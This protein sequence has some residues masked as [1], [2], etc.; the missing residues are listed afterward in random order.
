[1]QTPQPIARVLR[2]TQQGQA[3]QAVQASTTSP[4][5]SQQALQQVQPGENSP[6][7]AF[8]QYPPAAA[9]EIM[10]YILRL[11]VN[12]PAMNT[13]YQAPNGEK[14]TFWTV[15]A[16]QVAA[17][18]WSVE[19]TRFATDYMLRNCPYRE[20]RVAEF[21]KLDKQVQTIDQAEF[22]R[23]EESR[24]PHEPIVTAKIDG[25]W[26]MLYQADADRIGLTDYK[27]R[28]TTYEGLQMTPEERKQNGIYWI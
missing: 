18:G 22:A 28:Y 3:E 27:R 9:S 13:A 23:I 10:P 24:R 7:S 6:L 12:F 2:Q 15:L 14:I 17:L 19:R 20:F 26:V 21:L 4:A 8:R 5:L 16:D 25:R 11:A 1:M